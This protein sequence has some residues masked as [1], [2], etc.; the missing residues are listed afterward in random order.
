MLLCP[1]VL[2]NRENGTGEMFAE[3]V[4]NNKVKEAAVTIFFFFTSHFAVAETYQQSRGHQPI[5][6][7][8]S[9]NKTITVFC[10]VVR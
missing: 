8:D 1:V 9:S 4:L 7:K 2:E 3:K 10:V 6:P 5:R